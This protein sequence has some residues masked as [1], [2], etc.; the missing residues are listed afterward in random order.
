MSDVQD[1][2]SS[3]V[4]MSDDLL[5]QVGKT[6]CGNPISDESV[7][8]IVETIKTRL[9]LSKEDVVMDIGCGNGLLTN[10]ISDFVKHVIGVEKNKDLF[11]VAI[12]NNSNN[13][14]SYVMSDI[15]NIKRLKLASNKIN[16][17]EVLQHIPYSSFRS[18]LFFMKELLPYNG[19]FFIGGVLDEERKWEFYDTRERRCELIR[20]LM[21]N[22]EALGFWYHKDYIRCVAEDVGIKVDFYQQDEQLYT[23][24][25]RYDCLLGFS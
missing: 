21:E 5:Y 15:F 19:V 10:K 14:I 12:K 22:G 3:R 16:M 17:Y 18:F 2:Y 13:N 25:Y 8:I 4:A 23:S 6:V 7:N 20:G 24:H 11:E 9:D 1:Y